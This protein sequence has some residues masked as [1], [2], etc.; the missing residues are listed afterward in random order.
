MPC[1]LEILPPAKGLTM[2]TDLSP[3]QAAPGCATTSPTVLLHTMLHL[4]PPTQDPSA[5]HTRPAV[6]HAMACLHGTLLLLP[7][8]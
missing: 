1:T 3:D 5:R 6:H 8:H 2:P 7:D 4:L